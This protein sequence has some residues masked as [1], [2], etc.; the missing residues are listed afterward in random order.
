M[1]EYIAESKQSGRK[2]VIVGEKQNDLGVDCWI[3]VPIELYFVEWYYYGDRDVAWN[4]PKSKVYVTNNTFGQT[5][6][7]NEPKDLY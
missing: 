5:D 2:F 4:I 3:A 6:N 1:H 7:S